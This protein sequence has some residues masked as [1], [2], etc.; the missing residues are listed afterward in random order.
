[1]RALGKAV[2]ARWVVWGGYQKSG[3]RVRLTPQFIN[4]ETGESARIEKID[5]H[6]DDIFEMQDRIVIQLAA[7]LNIELTSTE[8]A[9]IAVPQTA[10]ISAYELYAKGQLA[11]LEFGKESARTATEYF[12]RAIAIDE[13]YALAWAGLGS[14]LMPKYIA[15][16]NPVDLTDGVT[17][18]QRAMQLDPS[19][20][21]PHAFLSYMYTQQGRF[22]EA[23]HAARTAI[24]RE[25]GHH[26]AWYLMA[27]PLLSRALR[28]GTLNDLVRAI[29][30]LLRSWSVNATFHPAPLV[31]GSIYTL[32]GQYAHAIP[33]LD[34]A[35]SREL[36]GTGQIFLGPL[37]ARGIVHARSGE[38]GAAFGLFDSAISRYPKLDHVYAET[39][40]AWALFSRGRL[41]EQVRDLPG[42]QRDFDQG[43]QLAEANDHRLAIG[44]QWLKCK[45]GLARLAWVRGDVE[46]SD[47]LLEETTT[48]LR[49]K[50][51]FIWISFAGG[52][53]GELTYEMASTC[54][55]R[56]ETTNALQWLDNAIRLGWSDAHQL[57]SDGSFDA[58][59]ETPALRQLMAHAASLITLP[60]PVDAGGFPSIGDDDNSFASIA[61][62]S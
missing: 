52:S 30:L 40:T 29:P 38:V 44:A 45:L 23:I 49:T 17:A 31:A 1:A 43:V 51:R 8:V 6:I 46:T 28:D 33:L 58:L 56:G 61:P 50:H 59:R 19:L 22:E 3:T 39:M 11:L 53:E 9:E 35:V 24:E 41:S 10:D 37:V 62:G 27:L 16:G 36:E 25:P 47:K 26:F 48:M 15:S 14:L 12:R 21:T 5:G 34:G 20:S 4:T 54:A 13:N 32:R 60:P 55:L 18:L 7:F 42:A 2:A 57:N